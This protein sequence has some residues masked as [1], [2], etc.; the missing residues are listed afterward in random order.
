M[1]RTSAVSTN[2]GDLVDRSGPPDRPLI[3]GVTPD[4]EPEVMTRGR[5]D[6]T[7]DA[8]ARGLVRGGIARGER[9]AILSANRPDT[10]AALLG[11]M[12]AGVVPVPVNHKFPPATI[13]T[14][15]ADCGAR[16]VLC[17]GPRREMLAGLDPGVRV[18]GFDDGPEGFAAWLDPGSF[19]P[20]VPEPDEAALFLYTSGSTGRPKGVRLSHASHLWVARTR[21][22]E[23]DLR[24]DRL[25]VAAPLYHM[26]ALAL[27]LLVCAAGATM[28]L[29]PQFEARAY[30]AAIDRHRCTWLTAVPPM[31]AMMLRE[32]DLLAEA[33][34]TGVRTVRMGSAPVNDALARQIRA[35]LPNARILNAYGTTEGGPVVFGDHPD[36]L[37]TPVASVGAPHPAVAVRLVGPDAPE[38]G[39]LQMQSSAIMLGYHNRPD[40]PV[41]ITADGFYDTGDVFRRDADGFYYVLGRTDDM[42]VSGGENIFPGEVELVLERH[43]AVLQACVVPVEDSIKGTKPVAFVVR[44]P[45]AAIDEGALKAHVLAHAPAYPHPRRIWFVE[46]LPLASTGKIDRAALRRRAEEAIRTP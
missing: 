40:V 11:A 16:L 27:A 18:A 3:I 12:R 32:R 46:A 4:A 17:D 37:P 23:T 45:G 31:I 20:I 5:L 36:G 7:A 9:I 19:M 26:N 13:A 8:F 6:A 28:V 43:P 22:A 24:D 34:L 14:V 15:L 2:L 25:L 1:T 35:L 33:D 38:T 21:A 42:F 44:R 41:P 10:I 39:V 30:I 29:L